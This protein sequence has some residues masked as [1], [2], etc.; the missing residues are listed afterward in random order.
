M[1]PVL[2]ITHP[3]KL[4][5][6]YFRGMVIIQSLI[7]L[8]LSLQEALDEVSMTKLMFPYPQKSQVPIGTFLGITRVTNFY[9]FIW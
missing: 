2:L 1:N 3:Q 4:K 7:N 9:H 6:S 8:K 5:L